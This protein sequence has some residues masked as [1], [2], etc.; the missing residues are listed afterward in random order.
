MRYL[1]LVQCILCSWVLAAQVRFNVVVPAN[2][3]Q[4]AAIYIAGD[5]NNWNPGAP[6]YQ[7]TLDSN[8]I[9]SVLTNISA[10][11][12]YFKITRGNW[13]TVE[14]TTA[15]GYLINRNVV[16]ST[17]SVLNVAVMGWED[18]GATTN[19]QHTDYSNVSVVT[20]S[21]FMPSLNRYRRV[22]VY[23]PTDYNSSGSKRY[24]VLYMHDGQ[25]I[26]DQG[27]SF[28]GE[29]GVDESLNVVMQYG[30]SGVVV[31]AIDNGGVTRLDEY[32][33][34]VNTQYNEGG[35]GDEYADFVANTLKPY[36]DDHYKTLPCARYT[37]IA[38]SS[39]G[40]LISLYTSLKY[41]DVFGKVG[42]LSP[43]FWFVRNPLLNYIHNRNV[44]NSETR[45]YFAS[46][47]NESTTMVPDMMRV[48]DSLITNGADSTKMFLTVRSYG[49]HNETF[50]RQEFINMYENI[51]PL[52]PVALTPTITTSPNN[53]NPCP[54][55]IVTYTTQSYPDAYYF[56]SVEGGTVISGGANDQNFV[57]IEWTSSGAVEV[58]VELK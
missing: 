9:Y 31:V 25:N 44:R 5:F 58:S 45:Y 1:F 12:H 15:G 35:E 33:P 50:W 23:L 24:P 22:W 29:W 27:T 20:D 48:R 46:G 49:A 19:A 16:V 38:G 18:Q 47:P 37:G 28:A 55:D 51:Y 42:M 52:A 41:P 40:A 30:N 4:G 54:G 8:G 43:A 10:G 13:A 11:T 26:F 56:W 34:W 2:T 53:P 14:G 32:S 57:Q 6:A 39:M 21:F 7:A 36:I 3:P 17:P